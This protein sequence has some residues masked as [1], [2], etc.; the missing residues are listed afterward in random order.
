M[1]PHGD[2]VSGAVMAAVVDVDEFSDTDWVKPIVASRLKISRILSMLLM[3]ALCVAATE[4]RRSPDKLI[5][6]HHLVSR[7]TVGQE[8]TSG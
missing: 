7:S 2:S 4:R 5:S 3:L 1:P 8:P 6:H